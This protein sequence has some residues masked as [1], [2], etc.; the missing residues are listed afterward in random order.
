MLRFR[1]DFSAFSL[2]NVNDKPCQYYSTSVNPNAILQQTSG[3][4]I[5]HHNLCNK[6]GCYIITV[7]LK[8]LK[9]VWMKLFH[10]AMP[11]A[12][13][14]WKID[15]PQSKLLYFIENVF[16][17]STVISRCQGN[18]EQTFLQEFSLFTVRYFNVSCIAVSV[19]SAQVYKCVVFCLW[20]HNLDCSVV[21]DQI[22][23]II[24][25]FHLYYRKQVATCF[26]YSLKLYINC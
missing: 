10:I 19:I 13:C 24:C 12:P 8:N 4:V 2:R 7:Y 18:V 11:C 21:F 16:L 3:S 14:L 25:R 22:Q 23:I 5:K 9:G 20:N 26:C 15:D 17:V 1:E 6:Y